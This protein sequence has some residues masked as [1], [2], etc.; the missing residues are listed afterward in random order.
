MTN[1][2]FSRCSLQF[3][4]PAVLF[5]TTAGYFTPLLFIPGLGGVV[6]PADYSTVT[7]NVASYGYV[8]IGI[9]PYW[10]ATKVGVAGMKRGGALRGGAAWMEGEGLGKTSAE[11][12]FQMLLWVRHLRVA[13]ILG[14][15]YTI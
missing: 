15:G 7:S 2:S 10:P 5:P 14:V 1:F 3:V 12:A 11:K 13:R 9:D 8:V 4:S 6:Y